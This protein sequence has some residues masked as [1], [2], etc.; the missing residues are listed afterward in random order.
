MFEGVP[1]WPDAGRF[2]AVCD[3]HKVNQFYTAPTAIRALMGQGNEWVEGHDLS[4]L[5]DPWHRGRA[6]QPRGL[7]LV[8][9]HRRQRDLPIVDTWW[10]TETGGHLLTRCRARRRR[11]PARRPCPSSAISPSCS[12]RS[13]ARKSQHRGRGR[14]VHQGQL[15]R[16]DAHRLGR[17]RAVRKDL[18]LR[19]Q[20]ILLFRATAAGVTRT[21]ITGSPA[22]SMT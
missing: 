15:A 7:E 10:Q 1:T 14:L 18:F 21:G 5:K 6:D 12:T 3:K 17:S 11:N 16:P 8:Q 19:L 2:W 22:A 9:R 13:P 20:G 4:S